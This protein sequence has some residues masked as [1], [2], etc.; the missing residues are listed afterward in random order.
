MSE[1]IE[2]TA[3]V[4]RGVASLWKKTN[5]ELS[6]RFGGNSMRPTIEPGDEVRLRCTD[7]VDVGDVIVYVYLDRVI[8][9]RL[10]ARGTE[11]LLTRGDAHTI[12]DPPVQ[13]D[14]IV[15]KLIGVAPPPRRMMRNVAYVIARAASCFG[16][17]ALG[18]SVVLM[19]SIRMMLRKNDGNADG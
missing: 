4:L 5:R 8:V 19:N 10:I 12:P 3:D 14:A 1:A 13:A 7:D 9:H 11:W 15:G 17:R 16:S 6:V 2:L 18:A